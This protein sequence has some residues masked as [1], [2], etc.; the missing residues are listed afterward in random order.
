M[1]AFGLVGDDLAVDMVVVRCGQ[2]EALGYL[3]EW[4]VRCDCVAGEIVEKRGTKCKHILSLQAV[5]LLPKG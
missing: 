5:G 1:A 3:N 4:G 2:L